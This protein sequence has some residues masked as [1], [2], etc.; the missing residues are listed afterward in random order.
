MNKEVQTILQVILA[1]FLFSMIAVGQHFPNVEST[2]WGIPSEP[3]NSEMNAMLMEQPVVLMRAS[4]DSKS[5]IILIARLGRGEIRRELN[6]RR[7]FNVAERYRSSLGILPGKIIT[8]EGERV[9]DFGRIEIYWSGILIGAL[10]VQKNQDIYV[11]CCSPDDRY[12]PLKGKPKRK[13][14]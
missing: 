6:K 14:N 3:Y 4:P 12:Y 10:P 11:D 5:A 8:A 13:R 9:N 7:L 2:S 1:L